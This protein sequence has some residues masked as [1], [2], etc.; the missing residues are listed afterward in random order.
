MPT[1]P[2]ERAVDTAIHEW[3]DTR[4]DEQETLDKIARECID[5]AREAVDAADQSWALIEA[6]RLMSSNLEAM[7]VGVSAHPDGW[8]RVIFATAVRFVPWYEIAQAAIDRVLDAEEAGLGPEIGVDAFA[9][10]GGNK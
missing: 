2:F 4:P 8:S 5:E 1:Q 7:F 3:L 10:T 9:S 6:V